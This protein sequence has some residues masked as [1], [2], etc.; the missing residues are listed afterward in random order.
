MSDSITKTEDKKPLNEVATLKQFASGVD[1]NVLTF[2]MMLS[3]LVL[4]TGGLSLFFVTKQEFNSLL[5][6]GAPAS[7]VLVI[8]VSCL[9]VDLSHL[10]MD[11]KKS[12]FQHKLKSSW[13]CDEIKQVVLCLPK[14]EKQVLLGQVNKCNKGIGIAFGCFVGLETTILSLIYLG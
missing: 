6:M 10:G 7:F 13:Q 8:Y 14:E 11:S 2:A 3:F 1:V 4:Q 12:L 9:L 5:L